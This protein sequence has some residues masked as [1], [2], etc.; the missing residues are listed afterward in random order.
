V[1]KRPCT[2][3]RDHSGGI[4]SLASVGRNTILA[5][6]ITDIG[7]VGALTK[8]QV[9]ERANKRL[10][11]A[12]TDILSRLTPWI[13]GDFVVAYGV[14]LTAWTGMQ[15]S[16]TWLLIVAAA[17]SVT[18]IV[19]GAF[20]ETG[21]AKARDRSGKLLRQL[22]VRTVIGFLVALYAAVAIPRS[23]WYEFGWFAQNE[24]SVTVTAGIVVVIVVFL[25][26]GFQK[27]GWLA[28]SPA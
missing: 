8:D 26:R 27:L 3:G 13:P 6:R 21:F 10:E 24:T 18:F 15:A 2:W 9:R 11:D 1:L 19:L 4:M 14:L 20:A 23:G 17:S 22:A 16:F 5:E 12:R 25:L 7:E 28:P